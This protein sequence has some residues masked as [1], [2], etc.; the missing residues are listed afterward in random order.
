MRIGDRE[1]L[2][3][4]GIFVAC[5]LWFLLGSLSLEAG[6]IS[7]PG[8]GWLPRVI[9]SALAVLGLVMVLR[10]F[11]MPVR[12]LGPFGAYPLFIMLLSMAVFALA[13]DRLGMLLTSASSVLLVTLALPSMP[14]WQRLTLVAGCSI[15]T[16]LVFSALIGIPVPVLPKW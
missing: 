3:A 10:S 6:S 1:E 12:Q 16:A 14:L 11:A 13:I 9:A 8:P 2:I 15:F 4:G 7:M 5:G